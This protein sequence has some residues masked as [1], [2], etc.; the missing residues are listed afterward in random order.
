MRNRGLIV[1]VAYVML[2]VMG[3]SLSILVYS[4]LK[5]S[6]I[7]PEKECPEVSVMIYNYSCSENQIRLMLKNQ[8]RFD[9]DGVIVKTSNNSEGLAVNEISPVGGDFFTPE[10]KPGDKREKL[11]ETNQEIKKI[12][13]IP[14]K[15]VEE[16][17]LICKRGI[18]N[19]E[20]N[21]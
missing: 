1:I 10:L 4:W 21:C 5:G 7:K 12:E 8:G 9:I 14:L 2:V 11:Y 16:E 13:I 19:Q 17:M 15:E 18:I 3:L 20:I 6:I